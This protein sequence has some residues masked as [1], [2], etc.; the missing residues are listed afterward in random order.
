M[1][2]LHLHLQGLLEGD[3]ELGGVILWLEGVAWDQERMDMVGL[4]G[5]VVREGARILAK[6]LFRLESGGEVRGY[7]RDQQ[8]DEVMDLVEAEADIKVFKGNDTIL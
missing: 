1:E 6:A 8:E 7:L 4:G 3:S 2:A 5:G